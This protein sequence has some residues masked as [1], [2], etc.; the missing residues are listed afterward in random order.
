MHTDFRT[1]ESWKARK[2]R[3]W[4]EKYGRNAEKWDAI[5]PVH[6]DDSRRVY[7]RFY[8]D[9]I[10]ALNEL[11]ENP[12]EFIRSAIRSKLIEDTEEYMDSVLE[13]YDDTT[14]YNA[15]FEGE[16]IRVN[17]PGMEKAEFF[18]KVGAVFAMRD[19]TGEDVKEISFKGT[20][21]LYIGWWPD[22]EFRFENCDDPDDTYTVWLPQYEH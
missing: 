13:E 14:Y 7:V 15:L 16:M 19:I 12:S 22:M 20:K 4:I 8:K 18:G 21:Y 1:H 10:E 2:L 11:P 3:R 6:T 17:C 5:I 9:V